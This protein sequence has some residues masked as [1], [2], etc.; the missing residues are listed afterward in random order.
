ML[1]TIDIGNSHLTLGAYDNETLGPRWRLAS[2]PHRSSDE[3]GL[4]L[5]GLLHYADLSAQS[6][7]GVCIASVVPPLT[8]SVSRA[9]RDY[10]ELEP[11]VVGAGVK[12]GVKI[13]AQEPR[14]VGADRIVNACAVKHLYRGPACV[15]D[16]GTA[17][18]FDAVN[19]E[20][21]YLGGAIAPGLQ[22]GADSLFQNTAKLP[23]VDIERPPSVIGRNTIHAIQSG[24]VFGY[25]SLVEGMV[26]RFVDELGDE[27]QTIATGGLAEVVAGETDVIDVVAPWLTLEGLRVIWSLNC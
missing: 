8:S 14:T 17:T 3:Y 9:C 10:L 23:K 25:V 1:L 26:G 5:L 24:L 16:F 13:L 18:T 2:A 20:G 11:L 15:V 12:T 22:L 27:M 7:E 4:Q 19:A 6:F 21:D